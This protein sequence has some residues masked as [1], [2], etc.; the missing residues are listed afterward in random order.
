MWNFLK[1]VKDIFELF[2]K[3][4]AE[5][6]EKLFEKKISKRVMVKI[7]GLL[8]K[9]PEMFNEYQGGGGNR[10]YFFYTSDIVSNKISILRSE[11]KGSALCE[12]YCFCIKNNTNNDERSLFLLKSD[13]GWKAGYV[14]ET[15]ERIEEFTRISRRPAKNIIKL[16]EKV[17]SPKGYFGSPSFTKD[18]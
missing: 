3:D 8:L 11:D 9:N 12:K 6:L 13:F 2:E 7:L 4:P 18:K 15:N 14:R 5:K 17:S 1:D 10:S 16:Y